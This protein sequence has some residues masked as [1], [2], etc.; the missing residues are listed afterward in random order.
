MIW[1]FRKGYHRGVAGLCR[2][3]MAGEIIDIY[4]DA[5]GRFTLDPQDDL[6]PIIAIFAKPISSS[7]TNSPVR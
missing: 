4:A 1:Q 2:I 5:N 6:T 3:E 7:D